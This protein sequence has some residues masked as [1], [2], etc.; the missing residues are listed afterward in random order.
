MLQTVC[1]SLK[2]KDLSLTKE[3]DW[4]YLIYTGEYRFTFY[5]VNS[6]KRPIERKLI[7]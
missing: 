5:S 1:F 4:I 3:I 7:V 6:Q 2:K